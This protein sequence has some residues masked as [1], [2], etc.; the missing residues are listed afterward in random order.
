MCHFQYRPFDARVK[1]L[2]ITFMIFSMSLENFAAALLPGEL[3]PSMPMRSAPAE[4][5]CNLALRLLR[6][7]SKIEGNKS[8]RND[9]RDDC[10]CERRR[11]SFAPQ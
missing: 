9:S 2:E 3:L 4:A 7:P 8:A 11:G 1:K 6:Q 5:F 10:H